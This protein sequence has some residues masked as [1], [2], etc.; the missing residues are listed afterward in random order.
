LLQL[1]KILNRSDRT[2]LRQTIL[3]PLLDAGL[4]AMT[5]PDKPSSSKQKYVTTPL[6]EELL[7]QLGNE[8]D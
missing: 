4:L 5:R 7:E 8:F 6:G 2:K 3:K 1:S